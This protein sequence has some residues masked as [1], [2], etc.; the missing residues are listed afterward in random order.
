MRGS[1]PPSYRAERSHATTSAPV[2]S[3]V[4]MSWT[5][6]NGRK[7]PFAD[8]GDHLVVR[9]IQML[10]EHARHTERAQLGDPLDDV[11]DAPGEPAIA[12]L[13]EHCLGIGVVAAHRK[14]A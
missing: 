7:Q 4:V 13:L 10:E 12:T 2:S 6:P 9:V 8:Q 11:L 1:S 14:E 3:V 5:L